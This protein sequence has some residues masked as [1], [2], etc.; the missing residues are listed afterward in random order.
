MLQWLVEVKTGV[1][2]IKS[3]SDHICFG[4]VS[5]SF[6]L[7]RYG[8]FVFIVYL[9]YSYLPVSFLLAGHSKK[10]IPVNVGL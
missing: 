10:F 8:V 9:V 3:I 2:F 1:T 5:V 7:N 6:V 4:E